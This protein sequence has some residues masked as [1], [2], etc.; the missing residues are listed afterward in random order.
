MPWPP[1]NDTP[2]SFGAMPQSV[3]ESAQDWAEWAIVGQDGRIRFTEQKPM[4]LRQSR[5]SYGY[6]LPGRMQVGPMNTDPKFT[7]M[8][9]LTRRVR[10]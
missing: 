2:P 7:P 3:F 5:I 8:N 10:V 6:F 4:L 9:S 1:I